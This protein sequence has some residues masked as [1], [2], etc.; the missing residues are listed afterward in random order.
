MGEWECEHEAGGLGK[1]GSRERLPQ[2][3]GSRGFSC[4]GTHGTRHS[5]T[6]GSDTWKGK[7]EGRV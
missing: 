4:L 2:A 1:S 6:R 7:S 5:R 3:I